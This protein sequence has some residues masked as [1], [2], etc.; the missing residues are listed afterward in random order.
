MQRTIEFVNQL[1][2]E[3]QEGVSLVDLSLKYHTDAHYQFKKHGIKARKLGEQKII[4]RKNCISLNWYCE[5]I[6]N[7]EEAYI[8]GMLYANGYITRQQ[9]GLKLKES[10]KNLVEKIKNYFSKDIKLQYDKK[11]KVYSFV[12]SSTTVI[13]NLEKLGFLR[14]KSKKE[15]QI[16]DMPDNLKRHFIRGYFDGDGSIYIC[17]KNN[18]SAYLKSYICSPTISILQ[19][20]QKT[21]EFNFISSSINKEQRKGKVLK[22]FDREVVASMDMYRLFIRKKKDLKKLYNFFYKNCTI[23]MERKKK[24]FDE[25]FGMLDYIHVNTEVNS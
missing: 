20:M 13:K 17:K 10:D 8:M 25:N 22:C 15:L 11:R 9:L 12:V 23:F 1:V 21:F 19:D 7:E 6:A 18:K 24:V 4:N 3:Y 2:R 5:C 14:Q 16:P